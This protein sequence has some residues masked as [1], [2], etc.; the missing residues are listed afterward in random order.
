[1]QIKPP[2]YAAV[3]DTLCLIYLSHTSAQLG[4]YQG[5][6]QNILG[7]IREIRKPAV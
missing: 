5:V 7:S 6:T 3:W 2:K 1:M 4:N